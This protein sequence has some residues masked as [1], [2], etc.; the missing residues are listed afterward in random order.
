MV[1][2]RGIQTESFDGFLVLVPGDQTMMCAH[3][4]PELSVTM[5]TYTLTHHF[6][7]VDI[8]DTNMILGVQWLIT[9]GKVTTD[10]KTLEMEW[11]DEKTGRH[12]KIRGQHT[13]PP[14][15]VL[16][17]RMEAVFRKGDMEWAVELRASEAGTTGQ[18]I[19]PEI[20]SILD[21]YAIVFGE[22]P[23]GQPPT[24]DLSTPLSLSKDGTL[25]MCIDYRALNKKTLK[26]RYPIPRI[27]ELMDELRVARFFLKIDLRFGYH[28]IRVREQ[29][30]PKTAFRCHYGHFE[31]SVMPFGLTNAHA[32]IQ[33]CMNHIFCSHLRKFVLVF[34]DDILIYSRT[35]QEHL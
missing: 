9:L 7:V 31:F 1:E 6:F 17:H 15:T 5:G 4:V 35:W 32:T 12:E 30:I 23:P 10:W 28:Q 22:I 18:T 26:N 8:L 27:D 11:D 3:Y 34:F 2:R 19:H 25:R 16:A 14:Q 29:G 33:S 20:Q 21:R 24:G 13:Y